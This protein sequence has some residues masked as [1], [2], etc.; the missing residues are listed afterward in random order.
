MILPQLEKYCLQLFD[1]PHFC[2]A[3]AIQS[4]KSPGSFE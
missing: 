3:I 2:S 1:N 4:W